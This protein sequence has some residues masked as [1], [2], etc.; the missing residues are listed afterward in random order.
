MQVDFARTSEVKDAI[1][2]RSAGLYEVL[3][4]EA[5]GRALSTK[6]DGFLF[7]LDLAEISVCAKC[8]SML[9]DCPSRCICERW[10]NAIKFGQGGANITTSRAI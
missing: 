1:A 4:R 7:E 9:L 6:V 2:T 5:I 3:E 8:F 10:I